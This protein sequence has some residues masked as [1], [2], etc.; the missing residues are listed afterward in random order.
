MPAPTSSL[1]SILCRRTSSAPHRS[2]AR[3]YRGRTRRRPSALANPNA[4]SFVRERLDC[5]RA[6]N[7]QEKESAMKAVL[8]HVPGGPEALQVEEVARPEPGADQVLIR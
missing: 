1:C 7:Q 3:F 6:P 4:S 8:L 2:P 5:A